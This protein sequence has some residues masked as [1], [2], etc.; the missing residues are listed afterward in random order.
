MKRYLI[1]Y[2]I[3]LMFFV[4]ALL[5][6]DNDI[7]LAIASACMAIIYLVISICFFIKDQEHKPKRQ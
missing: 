2:L 5:M 6:E 1:Y 3:G 4:I 7:V